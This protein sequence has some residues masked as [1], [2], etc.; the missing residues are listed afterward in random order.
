LEL[1]YQAIRKGGNMPCILNAA[2]EI[3]NAAFRKGNIHFIQIAEIIQKTMETIPFVSQPTLDTYF[4]TDTEA[5]RWASTL[6]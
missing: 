2:N 6:I 3:A 5:R 4:E 1:A